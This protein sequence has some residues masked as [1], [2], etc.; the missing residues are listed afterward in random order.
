MAVSPGRL[1]L[2]TS[3][4]ALSSLFPSQASPPPGLPLVV[5]SGSPPPPVCPAAPVCVILPPP[6]L[7]LALS[8]PLLR[9]CVSL[10]SRLPPTPPRALLATPSGFRRPDVIRA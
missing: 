8:S 6:V 4:P 9:C 2:S 1:L 7:A 3:H 10:R 5:T